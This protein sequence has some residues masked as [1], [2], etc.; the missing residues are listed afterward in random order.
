[1]K[2]YPY[3][4]VFKKI[5]K[6]SKYF[7]NYYNN[8]L[9]VKKFPEINENRTIKPLILS[10]EKRYCK[11]KKESYENNEN[12]HIKISPNFLYQKYLSYKKI[13]KPL[14]KRTMIYS[15]I[16]KSNSCLFQNSKKDIKY[17]PKLLKS[18]SNNDFKKDKTKINSNIYFYNDYEKEFFMDYS[19]L[20]YNEF[21]IYKDK[22]IYEKNIKEKIN[23]FKKNKKKID[24]VFE[25]I[26]IT[27]K[28]M[29]LPREVNDQNVVINFPFA[30]LPIFYYKGFEAFI[31]FLCFVI[32]VE[33]NFE[34][35]YYDEDKVIEALNNLKDFQ[36]TKGEK[37]NKND[38]EFER[39]YIKNR[40]LIYLK[41]PNLKR[42]KNHLNFNYFIFF[43]ITN[44]RTFIVTITLPCIY[45]NIKDNK[46]SIHHFIDYELIFFLYKRNFLNWDFY[47]IKYLSRYSK[48]RNIFQQIDLNS[49]IFNKPIFIKEPKTRIN[50]FEEDLL[51]NVYTDQFN[52][53]QIIQFESFFLIIYYSNLKYKQEKIY[54]IL[55]NFY[56]YVKLFEIKEYSN[57]ICF[58]SNFVE[59][60]NDLNIL[61]FKF[62]EYDEFDVRS[63]LSN[64]KKFTDEK[65]ENK[66]INEEIYMEFDMLSNRI[67]IEFKKPRWSIIKLERKNEIKR[68]WEIGNE[69]EKDFIES[70]LNSST[71]SW[72]NLLNNCLKKLN[73]P[74]PALNK[75]VGKKNNKKGNRSS[76]NSSLKKKYS[77]FPI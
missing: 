24:L 74:V 42:N 2:L 16:L 76:T 3:P 72:T 12:L 56:Q 69:L 22:A 4:F 41:A 17:G 39:A 5:I 25:S 57:K 15:Q 23:Y 33:N 45:L 6:D 18:L 10:E 73:E 64:I 35:I 32:K 68:T 53:N 52:K 58:I 37:N 11:I 67:K 9:S 14:S 44:L 31:K 1:M 43:W 47:I 55:F 7:K 50:T 8:L 54:H 21:E 38:N 46:I 36:D 62:K 60:N 20:K 30:L 51:F 26:V 75:E 71:E 49:K 29:S 70:I 27:F 59:I 19:N 63:W 61:N 13:L 65:L 40:N 48:F 66:I 77:Y 28:D 34:K